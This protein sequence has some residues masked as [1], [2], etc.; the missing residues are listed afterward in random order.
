V[1][2]IS[3]IILGYVIFGDIPTW[4]TLA[5]GAVVIGSGLYLYYRERQS[6]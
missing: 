1:G 2:L 5:G 3:M 4:W 6:G